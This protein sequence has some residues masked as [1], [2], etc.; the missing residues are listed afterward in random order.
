M[1]DRLIAQ[2]LKSGKGRFAAWWEDREDDRSK[3]QVTR[4]EAEMYK[5]W[6]L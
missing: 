1:I 6:N 5:G 4:A 2:G 3:D